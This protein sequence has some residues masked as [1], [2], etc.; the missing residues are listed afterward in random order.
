[1]KNLQIIRPSELCKLLG[2]SPSTLH[3]MEKRNE[4]PV[5]VEISERAVGWLRTDIEDWL[6]SKKAKV[7]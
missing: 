2:V 4:L 1:M 3:R 5:R 7:A 6:E